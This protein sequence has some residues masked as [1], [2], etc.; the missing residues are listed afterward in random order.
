MRICVNGA[1]REVAEGTTIQ[2]LLEALQIPPASVAVE[3][4][5]ELVIRK[6]FRLRSLCEGDRIE[7]VTFVGGG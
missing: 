5:A 2:G 1:Q 6:D 7:I 4:N 3:R